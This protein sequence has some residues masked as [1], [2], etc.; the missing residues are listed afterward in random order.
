M[1]SPRS[2][3]SDTDNDD[4]AAMSEGQGAQGQQPQSSDKQDVNLARGSLV[5]SAN[6]VSSPEAPEYSA[7]VDPSVMLEELHQLLGKFRVLSSIHYSVMILTAFFS[8]SDPRPD[9]P[10]EVT[11]EPTATGNAPRDTDNI[12]GPMHGDVPHGQ[13]SSFDHPDEEQQRQIINAILEAEA[14]RRRYQEASGEDASPRTIL[15]TVHRDE[16]FDWQ[17]FLIGMFLW[18]VGNS[19]VVWVTWT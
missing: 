8:D 6:V 11:S 1:P 15:I 18:I 14:R 17:T 16:E 19:L 3:L 5:P 7:A 13:S 12:P 9:V 4:L 10:V 2:A